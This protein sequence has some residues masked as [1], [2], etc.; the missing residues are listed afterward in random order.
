MT[1]QDKLTVTAEDIGGDEITRLIRRTY[2]GEPADVLQWFAELNAPD[3]FEKF[4]ATLVAECDAVLSASGW[5]ASNTSLLILKSGGWQED[6]SGTS[7]QWNTELHSG[8]VRT[9]KY[10]REKSAIYSPVWYS[11]YI[12]EL[13]HAVAPAGEQHDSNHSMRLIEL[14]MQLKDKLWRFAE[15]QAIITGRKQRDYL[16]KTREEANHRRS[17]KMENRRRHV[18]EIA[19]AS[20]RSKGALV[21]HVREVLAKEH[22]CHVAAI[23][24]RRD[25]N[26]IFK[27][28]S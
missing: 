19:K 14:G 5:P 12:A 26:A 22:N 25:L 8:A 17:T 20:K 1:D 6:T 16:A 18:A 21:E 24:V 10:V 27:A 11:A 4:V 23:T 3:K 28:A 7:S 13:C 15:K 9:T 2:E